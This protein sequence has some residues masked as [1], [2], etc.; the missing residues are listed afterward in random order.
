MFI[1]TKETI[2]NKEKSYEHLLNQVNTHHNPETGHYF[3]RS[4]ETV[5]YPYSNVKHVF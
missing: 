1:I 2:L 4:W 5:F 3:E